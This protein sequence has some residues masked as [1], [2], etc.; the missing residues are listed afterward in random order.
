MLLIDLYKIPLL[1]SVGVVAAIIGASMV[2]S[3]LRPAKAQAAG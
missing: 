1:G 3:L 2:L